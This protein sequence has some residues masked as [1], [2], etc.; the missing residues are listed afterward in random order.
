MIENTGMVL[1]A[2]LECHQYTVKSDM[3]G[4]FLSYVIKHK[5]A[6]IDSVKLLPK[7]EA[8]KE[9]ELALTFMQHY[10]NLEDDG[11]L[12]EPQA[13]HRVLIDRRKSLFEILLDLH[14]AMRATCVGFSLYF[15]GDNP[16]AGDFINLLLQFQGFAASDEQLTVTSEI[17]LALAYCTMVVFESSDLESASDRLALA[18]STNCAPWTIRNVLIQ[19][20]V[21]D[22]FVELVRSKLKPFTESQKRFLQ[23]PLERGINAA[24]QLGA[25]LVQS[26]SDESPTKPTLA[27]V[28]GVQFL[29]PQG[30]P[31]KATMSAAI[32]VLD[33][34]R[35]AKEAVALVNR[36]HGGSV[37]LWTEDLSL[38][39]EVAYGLRCG[40][41]WVN[42]YAELNPECPYTFRAQDFTYGSEYAICEKKVKTV[43]APTASTPVND[44]ETSRKA[45][46]SLGTYEPDARLYR[47]HTV[48]VKQGVHYE[49]IKLR[50][51]LE[52]YG[53][54]LAIVDNFW[55][56][57]VPLDEKDR[58]QV[59]DT[60][61][62]QRK[63]ICIPFG[64][65]FAN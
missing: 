45:I 32:V 24:N 3:P 1:P 15:Y 49:I 36:N 19:E 62:N 31:L 59:L 33:V 41:V 29:L 16:I 17:S 23:G 42:S 13:K 56:S 38:T 57:Y 6:L 27:F 63:V 44:T 25:Q 43:F 7:D 10:M 64:V 11:L 54:R 5:S 55:N 20:S 52:L 60:V 4:T 18:W 37:S 34:F 51:D 2:V 9:V 28:P 26:A 35:T 8:T 47:S 14:S 12:D 46:Q 39:F 21:K 30:S 61:H 58:R 40:T 48:L 50:A 22:E 65:T 53:L